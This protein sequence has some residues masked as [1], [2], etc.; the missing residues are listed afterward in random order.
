MSFKWILSY[1]YKSF[2]NK[3]RTMNFCKYI[4]LWQVLS[5]KRNEE[6][7]YTTLIL[8]LHTPR[9]QIMGCV[10]GRF[11][12]F[13]TLTMKIRMERLSVMVAITM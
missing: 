1:F 8:Y 6:K 2:K 10:P 9:I 11:G 12:K 7:G 4:Q 3:K 13:S 5:F